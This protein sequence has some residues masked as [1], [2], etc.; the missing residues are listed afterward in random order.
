MTTTQ[1]IVA[2]PPHVR[3]AP[4]H[5]NPYPYYGRLAREQ[6]VFRDEINGWWVVASAAAVNEVLTSDLCLTRPPGEPVPSAVRAGPMAEIFGRLVRIRNDQTRDRLKIAVAAAMRSLDLRTVADLTR[7]RAAELDAE[8]GLPLDENKITQFMFALPMQV[9]AQLL[10]I[11]RERYGDIMSWLGDYGLATASAA[12][13]VPAPDA[14]L[15][16]RGHHAAQTLIDLVGALTK[17]SGARGPLLDA[18]AQEARRAGCD[19][20][21]DIIANAIGYLLQGYAATASLIGLTLLALARRPSLRAQVE[22]DRALLREVIQEVLRC[23][24]TTNSTLRFMAKSGVIAGQE[25]QQGDMIIVL[26]AAANRDPALNPE[27]DRFD[28]SRKDRKYLELGAGAHAC[29]A[30]KF[31]PLIAMIAVDHLLTRGIPFE[32]LESSL[33][34]A[35]SGHIRTPMFRR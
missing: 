5:P 17:N 19:D 7:A 27:P 8:L 11:P 23:D 24:P 2:E 18:L 10:G 12:T 15:F 29:P 14:A 21:A 35:A 26:I 30:D 20:E 13:G 22:A 3:A 34:Y 25:M 9:T 4:P 31:A 32:R 28:I 1:T 6:P 33:S 16:A